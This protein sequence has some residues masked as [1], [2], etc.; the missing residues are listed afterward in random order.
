VRQLRCAIQAQA[1]K[2]L[3]NPWLPNCSQT[4]QNAK[5]SVELL[6]M[7]QGNSEPTLAPF[8][9]SCASSNSAGN[10]ILQTFL[11]KKEAWQAVQGAHR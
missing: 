8:L 11:G 6:E 4:Q 10:L 1:L 5:N 9:C 2:A 7:N 3:K